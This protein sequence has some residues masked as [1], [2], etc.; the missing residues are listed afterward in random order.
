LH[1]FVQFQILLQNHRRQQHASAVCQTTMI[2]DHELNTT[3]ND[4]CVDPAADEGE[5][6]P[7]L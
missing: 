6:L 4:S 7:A 2:S 5:V 3:G 1:C